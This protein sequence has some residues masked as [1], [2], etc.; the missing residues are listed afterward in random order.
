MPW[1]PGGHTIEGT[2]GD[3]L[4]MGL[5]PDRLGL[6]DVECANRGSVH[7]SG[8]QTCETT[9]IEMNKLTSKRNEETNLSRG[10]S[11]TQPSLNQALSL[12][13]RGG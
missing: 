9:V 12:A 3:G 6:A 8:Q 1:W 11:R 13:S 2:H 10:Q 7:V 4:V 5:G